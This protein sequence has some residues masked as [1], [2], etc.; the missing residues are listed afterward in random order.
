MMA[1]P[2]FCL[3]FY[4]VEYREAYDLGFSGIK[5]KAASEKLFHVP[6]FSGHVQFCFIWMQFQVSFSWGE[7]MWIL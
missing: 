7:W 4:A 3:Q 1:N 6:R 2:P 5:L